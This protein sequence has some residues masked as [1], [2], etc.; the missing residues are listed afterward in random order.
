VATSS[1]HYRFLLPLITSETTASAA[2]HLLQRQSLSVRGIL[3]A[4]CSKN[5]T[6]R[7]KEPFLKHPAMRLR[8]EDISCFRANWEN[9]ADNLRAIAT[10]LNIGLDSL[11][12]VDDTPAECE[13]VR[14]ELPEVT[15][16]PLP[17]DPS[18][19]VAALASGCYFEATSFTAE[20]VARVRLYQENTARESA[21]DSAA[22]L[23]S[24]L[25]GLDMEA[26]MGAA[27]SYH[28]PR[29]AQLLGKT[30]QFH[31]TTTRQSEAELAALAKDP[32]VWLRWFSLRDRFGDHGL[33]SVAI[34]RAERDAWIIDS[35]AMSCR[36]FSRGMEDF[37][38]SE[39]VHAARMAG[40][41]RLIGRYKPTA[42]NQVVAK[43]YGRFGFSLDG[44][45][46]DEDR[47]VLDLASA[48]LS[49][50]F[51]RSAEIRDAVHLAAAR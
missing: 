29:M 36:V 33:I 43:L 23:D 50:P 17:E 46:A 11:V 51:I 14:G 48:S 12:F 21:M 1:E 18:D 34:L 30:N 42:K 31:L 7:A 13:L 6:E 10:S 19:Y 2:Q 39:M 27:D 38:L 9:K 37:I 24:F 32:S 4:V 45:A 49:Q 25:R 47:W 40:A 35:W 8:L 5:D 20:D 22:D 41:A 44:Q 16:V 15:V 3:L 26:N 28:L